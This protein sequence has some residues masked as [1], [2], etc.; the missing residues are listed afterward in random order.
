MDG[1]LTINFS[2][3]LHTL[4]DEKFSISIIVFLLVCSIGY[5]ALL[6]RNKT[7]RNP[8]G[9][10]ALSDLENDYFLVRFAKSKDCP[11]VLMGDP[12][13]IYCCYLM[14]QPLSQSFSTSLDHPKKIVVWVRLLGL[15][16]RYYTKNMLRYMDEIVRDIVRIDFNILEGKRGHFT[17]II[18]VVNLNKPLASSITIDGVLQRIEYEGLPTICYSRGR[19]SHTLENC[20]PVEEDTHRDNIIDIIVVEPEEKFGPW[21][22]VT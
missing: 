11:Q 13:L 22:Q 19:Y 21:M 10:I 18:V 1:I 3:R 8:S 12:C 5:V 9:D 7:L 16:Y 15:S 2:E 6:S 20:M 14:V 17:K 4:V